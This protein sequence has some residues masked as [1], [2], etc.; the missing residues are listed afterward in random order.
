[1]NDQRS[2]GTVIIGDVINSG[3]DRAGSVSSLTKMAGQLNS[4]WAKDLL[5][6]FEF[7]SGD[8][9]QGLLTPQADPFRVI[10]AASLEATVPPMRWAVVFGE[11]LPGTGSA[12]RRTGEAFAQARIAIELAKSSRAGIVV[13][14]GVPYADEILRRLTPELSRHLANL[15]PRQREIAF[16]L[17]VEGIKQSQFAKREDVSRASISILTSRGGVQALKDLVEAMTM[18]YASAVEWSSGQR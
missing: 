2:L 3:R 1:M 5:A 16:A 7:T 10:L 18:I 15:T 12:I 6:K 4:L 17:I 14:T 8:E 9:I 11:V 13:I